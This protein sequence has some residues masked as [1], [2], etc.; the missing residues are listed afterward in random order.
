MN[1]VTSELTLL[2]CLVKPLRDGDQL[3]EQVYGDL[4]VGANEVRLM[5][6]ELPIIERAAR[7]RSATGLGPPDAFHAASAL[8]AGVA[9]FLTNDPR[10][11]RVEGL[12]A[13]ILGEMTG[14]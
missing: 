12:P 4:L 14:K 8:G 11:L 10:F 9:L 1:V 2:E 3:L 6:I 7:I 5:P 13:A